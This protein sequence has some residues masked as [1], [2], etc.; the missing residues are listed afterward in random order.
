MVAAML[1]KPRRSRQLWIERL[2]GAGFAVPAFILLLL[3]NL[4][5]LIAVL[6]LSLTDYE[7][8]ALDAGF[9]GLAN[10]KKALADPIIRRSV[11]NTLLYVAIVLPGAVLLA[12]LI[13]VLVHGRKRS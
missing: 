13:A 9:V 7:L 6:Y 8:G 12:L 2:T 10:L 4:L 11:S 3:V 5:P 1:S